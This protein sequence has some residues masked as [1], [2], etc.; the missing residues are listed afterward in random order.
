VLALFS[1]TRQVT[2]NTNAINCQFSPPPITYNVE[3]KSSGK[4]NYFRR[5]SN[6]NTVKLGYKEL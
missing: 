1:L 2:G 5:D 3:E 4:E 6:L